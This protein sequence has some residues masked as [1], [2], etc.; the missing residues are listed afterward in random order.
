V[1]SELEG[2]PGSLELVRIDIHAYPHSYLAKVFYFTAEEA[3]ALEC[4][5]FVRV[6]EK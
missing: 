1:E 3:T 6:V 5:C 4:P 2:M